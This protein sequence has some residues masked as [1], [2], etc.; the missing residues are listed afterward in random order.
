MT[1]SHFFKL[2][3]SFDG[4]FPRP[5]RSFAEARLRLRLCRIRVVPSHATVCVSV[6]VLY[7]TY[8]TVASDPS[9]Q[10]R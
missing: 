10:R 5:L 8:N 4:P 1:K 9:A 3:F 6:H 7:I 2:F